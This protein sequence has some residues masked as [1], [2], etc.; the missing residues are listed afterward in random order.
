MVEQQSSTQTDTAAS[1]SQDSAH[2]YPPTPPQS[3]HKSPKTPTSKTPS[4]RLPSPPRHL[5]PARHESP[6][7]HLSPA[8]HE[9][10]ARLPSPARQESPAPD[11]CLS[12]E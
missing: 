5:S 11:T 3:D 6:A 12:T 1:T 10:P 8:R 7:R 4:T 2:I 9:S